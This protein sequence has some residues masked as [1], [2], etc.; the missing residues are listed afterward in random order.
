MYLLKTIE[1]SVHVFSTVKELCEFTG[2]AYHKVARR[3][4][5]EGTTVR[6][7]S[8]YLATYTIV[9]FNC[10]KELPLL[11]ADGRV[12]LKQITSG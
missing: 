1:S 12:E 6:F 3:L 8:G 4:R 2:L 10:K 11:H 9:K 7:F 5:E